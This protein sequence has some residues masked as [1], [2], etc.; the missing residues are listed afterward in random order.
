MDSAIEAD[1]LHSEL[2]IL[3]WILYQV[4]RNKIRSYSKDNLGKAGS[5]I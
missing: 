4:C 2:T 3:D 1:L 5:Y